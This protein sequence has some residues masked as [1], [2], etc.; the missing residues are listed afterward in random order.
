[1][2]CFLIKVFPNE[3]KLTMLVKQ[4]NFAN[5]VQGQF[6]VALTLWSLNLLFKETF[7]SGEN[8]SMRRSEKSKETKAGGVEDED[9]VKESS[10]RKLA[11]SWIEGWTHGG[12]GR[13]IG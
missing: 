2:C 4:S 7:K 12:N 10:K 11:M 1:M 8:K 3:S 5:N 6:P 13:R 9:W